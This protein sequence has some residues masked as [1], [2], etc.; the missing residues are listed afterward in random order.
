M[1]NE[2]ID[3][4]VERIA[5][6]ISAP[7]VADWIVAAGAVTTAIV[8]VGAAIFAWGQ[9]KEA[10]VA[11]RQARDL[12]TNRSQPYVVVYAESSPITPL[13]IDLVVRNYGLTAAYGVKV[14]ISPWPS[15][16]VTGEAEPEAV[17]FP[18]EIAVLAPGQEWRTFWDHSPDRKKSGLPDRFEGTVNYLG[19][20]NMPL[21][22]PIVLDWAVFKSRIWTNV[23]GV[24]DA[25][26]ALREMNTTMKAWTEDAR[27]SLGVYTRDGAEKD[28]REAALHREFLAA[29][30]KANSANEPKP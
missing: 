29:R 10:R 27:G 30:A 26:K 14:Q 1:D 7:T 15:R 6:A 22:Q 17:Q 8:A 18:Y 9:V 20:D 3:I 16:F 2:Q 28:Q 24:H 12:D 23:Y 19:I 25:A 13:I 21:S 11:R 4:W 5:G